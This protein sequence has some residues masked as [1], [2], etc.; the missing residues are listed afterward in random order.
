MK[1]KK[2]RKELATEYCEK[3]NSI[4]SFPKREK[5]LR[6]FE[7]IDEETRIFARHRNIREYKLDIQP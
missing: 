3:I 4:K 2:T 7:E 5:L 1:A 6:E